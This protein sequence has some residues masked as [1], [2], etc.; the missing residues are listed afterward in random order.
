MKQRTTLI[1]IA[2]V[3]VVASFIV[4]ILRL[5]GGDDSWTCQDGKWISNGNPLAP[6]PNYAC[7]GIEG[8]D[9]GH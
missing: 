5:S 6:K 7:G 3:I 1:V 4:L 2:S 8:V 9:S